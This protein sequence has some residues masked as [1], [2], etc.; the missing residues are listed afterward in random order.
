MGNFGFRMLQPA[1]IQAAMA[2]RP[3]Y[4][5]LGSS[6]SRSASSAMPSPRR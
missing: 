3:G 2:F 4:Q 1:D 5:I 6:E